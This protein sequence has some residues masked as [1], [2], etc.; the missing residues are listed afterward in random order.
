MV[1]SA[2]LFSAQSNQTAISY[3]Y[4]QDVYADGVLLTSQTFGAFFGLFPYPYPESIFLE[5]EFAAGGNTSIAGIPV[6]SQ[7]FIYALRF[8]VIKFNKTLSYDPDVFISL[9]FDPQDADPQSP[10]DQELAAGVSAALIAVIVVVIVVVLAG[11]TI[12][13][14]KVLPFL[15]KRKATD[16]LPPPDVDEELQSPPAASQSTLDSRGAWKTGSRPPATE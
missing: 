4:A 8:N 15:A 7:S 2:F 16:Q 10:K 6:E 5:R 1:E 11:L 13:A 14:W 9:L 3:Q 12:F